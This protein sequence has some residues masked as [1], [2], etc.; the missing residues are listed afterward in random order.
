MERLRVGLNGFARRSLTSVETMR[1]Y[2]VKALSAAYDVLYIDS[3]ADEWHNSDLDAVVTYY[4][5]SYWRQP[6]HPPFP[7]LFAIHGDAVSRQEFLREHLI[8]LETADT[9]I[10]NCLSDL[11]ILRKMF[12]GDSPHLCHLHFPV[13]TTIFKKL[14]RDHCIANLGLGEVDLVVGFVARLIPQKNLHQ[15]LR[16]FAVLKEYLTPRR[17]TGVV[18]GSFSKAYPVLDFGT[19]GYKEYINGLQKQLGIENDIYF[20]GEVTPEFLAQ[21]YGAMDILIHPTNNLEEAF[22]SAPVEAMACG[23]PVVGSAYGGLKDTVVPHLT[24]FLMPTWTT[25]AGIRMDLS[26]GVQAAVRLLCD[27]PLRGRMS[28]ACIKRARSLYSYEAFA[29][30]LCSAVDL[31]VT[32]RR[33]GIYHRLTLVDQVSHQQSNGFLPNLQKPWEAYADVV[34]EYVSV[35]KPE[36]NLL[37]HLRVAGPIWVDDEGVYHLDDPA[38]PGSFH[39]DGDDMEI[40]HLCEREI[41]VAEL[42]ASSVKMDKLEYLFNIGLLIRTDTRA[43]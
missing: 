4:D 11:R 14:D 18:A 9:L 12:S 43:L 26:Y 16:M 38:W 22:G 10:V 2:Y 23:T 41:T 27:S 1:R 30:R 21:C 13:D 28:E 15:F 25:C 3:P 31:S 24:G 7:L 5:P 6:A 39:L 40:L 37:S 29:A 42:L 17:I 8:Y 35:N 20:I 34:S 32:H 36:L 33:D 19:E